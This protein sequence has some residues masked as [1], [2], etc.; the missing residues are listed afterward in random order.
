MWRTQAT[1]KRA[2][3]EYLDA[4][5]E[6]LG[7]ERALT[8]RADAT[9]RAAASSEPLLADALRTP[10]SPPNHCEGPFVR[11]HMRIM[12]TVLYAVVEER[13]HLID[14][15][16]FCRLKGYEGEIE[17]LEET[18][19]EHAAFFEVFALC[20]DAAKWSAIS[21]ES[22][23]GS[24]GAAL[25]FQSPRMAAWD[26]VGISERAK[27]RERY[28]E[29]YD[30]F[31]S[32]RANEPGPD[33]QTSFFDAYGIRIHYTGHDR[34]I[35]SPAYRALLYRLCAAH[36]LSDQ[37]RNLLEDVIA[38]HLE[39][40]YDFSEPRAARMERYY[41][42]ARQRAYDSD[43]FIDLL[44][45]GLFLDEVCASQRRSLH[46]LWHDSSILVNFLRAEFD[47]APMERA[48][49]AREREQERTRLQQR[50]FREAQL[51]GI[52]LMELIGMD[53]GPRFGQ[54]LR[55]IHAGVLG[56]GELPAFPP[57][58]KNELQ[59]RIDR[60]YALAFPQGV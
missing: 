53:P 35:H 40:I 28:L 38:H 46:G 43:D 26:D 11:D 41:E 50:M 12:L 4:A 9:L 45:A 49:K 20:H 54:L 13:L 17:E 10:Q 8:S 6:R 22:A 31:S 39:P 14:I 44:Q 18:L 58:I 42:I 3:S 27:M 34:L 51:D 32:E 24:R 16:E 30:A 60:F 21:F 15:E 29:L 47:F 59:R 19:K 56:E 52:A 7:K 57:R 36:R 33:Q 2:E 48:K 1:H 55:A 25:G 37:E 23:P 5:L